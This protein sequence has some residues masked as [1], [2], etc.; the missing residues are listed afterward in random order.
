MEYKIGDIVRSYK[1]DK[2]L[3]I[4][5]LGVGTVVCD[6]GKSYKI[7]EEV[8]YILCSQYANEIENKWKRIAKVLERALMRKCEIEADSTCPCD[9][10]SDKCKEC[11][12][13]R[14]C[15]TEYATQCY[16]ELAIQKAE[17]EIDKED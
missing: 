14:L 3:R 6:D 11:A 15:S 1:Q 8:E 2:L 4:E 12:E 9:E 16:F 5:S 10:N 17:F 7:G 13:K